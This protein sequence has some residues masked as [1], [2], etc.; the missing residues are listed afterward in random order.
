MSQV[1]GGV[2]AHAAPENGVVDDTK[3]TRSG[4][5]IEKDEETAR[6]AKEIIDEDRKRSK[7][8]P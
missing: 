2:Y 4:E 1:K 6:R 3:D 8:R 5:Q 7:R